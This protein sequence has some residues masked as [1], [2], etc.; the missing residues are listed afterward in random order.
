MASAVQFTAAVRREEGLIGRAGVEQEFRFFARHCDKA[1]DRHPQNLRIQLD[2]EPK[3]GIALCCQHEDVFRAPR[4]SRHPVQEQPAKP[5][6]RS[7]ES[8]SN[9]FVNLFVR[10]HCKSPLP[11]VS[12]FLLEPGGDPSHEL[13][14]GLALGRMA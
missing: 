13:A 10:I 3:L 5:Y 7:V 6:A 9:N 14:F 12:Q 8:M 2:G 1:R 4:V 11:S